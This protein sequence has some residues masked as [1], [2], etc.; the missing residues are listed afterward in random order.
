MSITIKQLAALA[1]EFDFELADA[2]RFLG[3][4]EPKKRGRPTKKGDDSDSDDEKC[5]GGKSTPRKTETPRGKRAPTGYQLFMGSTAGKV[6]AELKKAAG[7]RKL[8]PG[9]VITEVGKRWKGLTEKQRM[10]WVAK[11]NRE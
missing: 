4:T 5:S 6:S 9:A 2:R 11:A 7:D 10:T 1:E 8:A 3:H